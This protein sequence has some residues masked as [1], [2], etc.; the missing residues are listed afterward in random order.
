VTRRLIVVLAAFLI[1]GATTAASAYF[2][3]NS[4]SSEGSFSTTTLAAPSGLSATGGTSITL[5]WTATPSAYATGTRVLRATTS[6][7]PYSQVAQVSPRTTTSYVDYPPGAGTY[8]YVVAAYYQQWTSAN[9]AQVG[10]T[11]SAIAF[12]QTARATGT[13]TATATFTATPVAGNLLVA[14]AATR[15]AGTITTP[16]GWSVAVDSGSSSAPHQVIYYKIAGALESK[17]VAIVTTALGTGNGLHIYEYSGATTLVGSGSATGSSV[18]VGSGSVTPSRPYAVVFT[19]IVANFG[20]GLT[21]WTNSFLEATDFTAGSGGARTLLAGAG[22]LATASG[23]YSTAATNTQSG[24]WLG[25]IV[26]FA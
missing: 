20:T 19:G 10:A 16:L 15:Q 21:G 24:T 25:Q 11:R 17:S 12:V 2:N 6:G 13:T 4:V 1:F 9:T 22:I 26:A 3:P 7:G 8:Y 23:T 5:N 14:V 18:T